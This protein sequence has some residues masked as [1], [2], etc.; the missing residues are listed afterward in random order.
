MDGKL[1]KSELVKPLHQEAN[2]LTAVFTATG[3]TAK[4]NPQSKINYHTQSSIQNPRSKIRNALLL[5]AGIFLP[6]DL[7]ADPPPAAAGL[8][9]RG[10][11][12]YR[13][14]NGAALLHTHDLNGDGMDDIVFAN[15]QASRLEVLLRAQPAPPPEAGRAPRL[16]EAF[17]NQGVVVDQQ[18]IACRTA[19][20]YGSGRPA[21]LTM[22]REL[23]LHAYRFAD[24]ALQPAQNIFLKATERLMDLQTADL[25]GDGQVDIVVCRK[26]NLEILWNDGAGRFARRTEI[27]ITPPDALKIEAA[28]FTGDAQADLLVFLA[29]EAN[30]LRLRP[31]AGGGKFGPECILPIAPARRSAALQLA[32]E[33]PAQIGSIIQSGRG[34]RLYAIRPDTAASFLDRDEILP[35]RI[36]LRGVSPRA[37]PAWAVSDFD[38][39]G[40]DDCCV[41]APE[42]GQI[43]IYPGNASG[44]AAEPRCYDSLAG[45]SAAS[46]TD[47]GDLLVF[48]AAEKTAAVHERGNP[49]VF[50]RLLPPPSP[51]P[52]IAAALPDRPDAIWVCRDPITRAATLTVQPLHADDT[53]PAPYAFPIALPNDPD[54]IRVFQ[55]ADKTMGIMLFIPYQPPALYLLSDTEELV[56]VK[57]ASFNTADASLRPAMSDT[58]PGAMLLALGKVAREFAWQTNAWHPRRQFSPAAGNASLAAAVFFQKTPAGRGVVIFDQDGNDLL[59]FDPAA[60]APRRLHIGL[61]LAAP[62]G[63]H[64]LRA[65]GGR[66]DAGLLLITAQEI[67]VFHDAPASF[68]LEYDAEYTSPA[69]EP[70][71]ADARL[72]RLG[73]P[74]RPLV[75]L[76]D[77]RN[78]ALEIVERGN[79]KLLER[80][81]FPVF[82]DPG[83][84]GARAGMEP[85]EVA[86]GDINGDG[87]GDLALLTH[88]KLIIYLGE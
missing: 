48:S 32:A 36:A 42:L 28:D 53:A 87:I 52:L 9:F 4:Q 85:R 19:D 60:D 77:T 11:E 64:P 40:H 69:D 13:F 75:A 16:E 15:N 41:A 18:I 21:I 39:D 54:A 63:L 38:G 74:P 33:G 79:R 68:R 50:P 10:M 61:P 3:R 1:I 37:A 51:G 46:L 27:A 5:L 66:Q 71:L 76:T 24:S 25:D 56:N 20:L 44:L 22:G 70:S 81:A 34:L 14:E 49:G 6:L 82:E 23:G 67:F 35:L 84:A 78:R 80:L 57:S 30:L 59:W 65:A 83:F 88:D 72:V 47:S 86:A 29:G 73:R 12:I 17:T 45:I 55:V 31:G 8:G 2:E 62:I 43:H 26:D 58:R 7:M